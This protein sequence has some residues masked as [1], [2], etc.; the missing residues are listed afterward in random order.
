MK[1]IPVNSGDAFFFFDHVNF[2]LCN[3]KQIVVFINATAAASHRCEFEESA[4][5]NRGEKIRNDR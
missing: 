2:I 3:I 4:K 1:G 5:L